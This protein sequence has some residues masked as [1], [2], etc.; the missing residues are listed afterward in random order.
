MKERKKMKGW[1]LRKQR[2]KR[3]EEETELRKVRREAE[4]WK[5]INRKRNKERVKK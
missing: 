2:E 1:L 3:E 4:V 5:Y